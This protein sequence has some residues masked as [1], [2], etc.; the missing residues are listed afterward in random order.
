MSIPTR[1]YVAPSDAYPND[2]ADR[3]R[4]WI[5]L[6][7]KMNEFAT[8]TEEQKDWMYLLNEPFGDADMPIEPMKED[9]Q[10]DCVDLSDL[11]VLL[12]DN[13]IL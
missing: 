2:P 3:S 9:N 11:T 13:D 10:A 6:P 8:L 1:Q 12:N 7:E 4:M 5:Y